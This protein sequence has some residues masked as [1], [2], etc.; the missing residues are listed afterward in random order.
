LD[1]GVSRN[2]SALAI[3][4]VRR[5]HSGHGKMALAHLKLWKPSGK[6]RVDLQAVEDDLFDLHRR[7]SLRSLCYDPWQAQ[8]MASRLQSGGLSV[9]QKNL[10][11]L[12]TPAVRI[13]M[14][15]VPPTSQNMQRLATSLLE[16]FNDHRI[17]LFEHGDLRR[18]L[19][20]LRVEERSYGFRLVSPTSSDGSH[21][22]AATALQLAIL[23]GS[24]MAAKK[25]QVARALGTPVLSTDRG[26][27]GGMG[28]PRDSDSLMWRKLLL[29]AGRGAIG[30]L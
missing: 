23:A 20:K 6:Q 8:H 9:Y 13:P 18:D 19:V 12:Q 3:I 17:E 4:G 21:G 28:I 11:K 7:F 24:E 26:V 14:V 5:T 25:Q 16:A 2:W 1:L 30:R 15:E 10:S 29:R 22:D 27:F